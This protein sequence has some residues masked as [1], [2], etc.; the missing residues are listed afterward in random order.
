MPEHAHPD[1]GTVHDH[2]L[3]ERDDTDH[4][5]RYGWITAP[6]GA[7][8]AADPTEPENLHATPDPHPANRPADHE[9]YDR[10]WK[11]AVAVLEVTAREEV[12][13]GPFGHAE[14]I[15]STVLGAALLE[16]E[17]PWRERVDALM[18]RI[19]HARNEVAHYRRNADRA[20]AALEVERRR[21]DTAREQ[22]ADLRSRLA[23][24]GTAIVGA[25]DATLTALRDT[26]AERARQVTEL[27]YTPEHDR[28]HGPGHVLSYALERIEQ[29]GPR[30][31][32]EEL[33]EAAALIIAAIEVL[34]ARDET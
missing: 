11:A 12:V 13:V 1:T 20:E 10:A 31:D 15:V 29:A 4:R 22:Y 17:R 33:V 25:T 18:D 34:D 24:V 32:R 30:P 14:R 8:L 7:I 16:L 3:P 23:E 2:A 9:V 5:H 19:R 21:G 28:D 27:G 26:A 6:D